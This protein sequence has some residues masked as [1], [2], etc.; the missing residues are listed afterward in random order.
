[1]A[2]AWCVRLCVICAIGCRAA[3]LRTPNTELGQRG[4]YVK[5]RASWGSFA[6]QF[7]I[8]LA[9]WS[10]R[11]THRSQLM[12]AAMDQWLSTKRASSNH[13]LRTR[14]ASRA[15]LLPCHL[16]SSSPQFKW[17]VVSRKSWSIRMSQR[18]ARRHLNA[19]AVERK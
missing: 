7:F 11:P 18:F 8:E 4:H 10:G 6:A 17:H 14:E 19:R 1:M 16:G 9:A 2:A 5:R 3:H 12:P 13:Y 15:Q